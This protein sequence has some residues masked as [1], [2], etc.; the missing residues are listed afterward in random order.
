MYAI[1]Q[2]GW[3][4]LG[5]GETV[6]AALDDARLEET[7]LLNAT[8]EPM[9]V[10]QYTNY[11]RFAAP[12]LEVEGDLYMRRCSLSLLEAA[13]DAV[14][15]SLQYHVDAHGVVQKGHG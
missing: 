2:S 8:G 11:T 1:Y 14:P 7:F 6:D 12:G 15:S 3:R 13:R 5:V 10:E 9:D 4:L